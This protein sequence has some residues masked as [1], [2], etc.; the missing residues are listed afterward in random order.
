[1]K[2]PPTVVELCLSRAEQLARPK[3]FGPLEVRLLPG[4]RES[5]RL[6]G[7]EN[8]GYSIARLPEGPGMA[9]VLVDGGPSLLAKLGSEMVI[10]CSCS[11]GT[12][13]IRNLRHLP[14]SQ[15]HQCQALRYGDLVERVEHS[16]PFVYRPR[17]RSSGVASPTGSHRAVASD[18]TT[19]IP[20][21][22]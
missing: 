10:A 14:H 16:R 2:P 4:S 5:E 22:L 8:A 13:R 9:Y 1:M 21:D 11:D 7:L 12:H 17:A 18:P 20:M 19:A 15:Q 3:G 6:L